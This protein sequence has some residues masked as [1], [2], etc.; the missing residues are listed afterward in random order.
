[1][2]KKISEFRVVEREVDKNSAQEADPSLGAGALQPCERIKFPESGRRNKCDESEE[3]V[4]SGE[5]NDDDE[6]YRHDRRENAKRK[7]VQCPS[8]DDSSPLSPPA[9][10]FSLRAVKR[11]K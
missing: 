9:G 3:I 2:G 1:M 10:L 5:A 11:R 8:D 4:A 6:R 7:I